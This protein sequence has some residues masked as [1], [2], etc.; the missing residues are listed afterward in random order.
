MTITKKEARKIILLHQNLLPG[1]KLKG[2]QD[3]FNFIQKVG[4]IQFDPLDVIAMNPHLVLQSRIGKYSPNMLNELLY[5]DRLLLDGW[6]KNMSIYPI[7]E[8][9]YEFN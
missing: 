3:I 2:K 5:K 4:C 1:R 9:K 8:W 6:D 7:D